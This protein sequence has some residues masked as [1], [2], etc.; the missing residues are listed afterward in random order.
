MQMLSRMHAL[1]KTSGTHLSHYFWPTTAVH[2]KIVDNKNTWYNRAL[3]ALRGLQNFQK[4][5]SVVAL[6]A[7]VLERVLMFL[8]ISKDLGGP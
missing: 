8:V 7:V 2:I 3:D 5:T 4:Y 6:Y 1:A